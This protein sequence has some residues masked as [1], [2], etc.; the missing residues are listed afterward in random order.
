VRY[1]PKLADMVAAFEP[2]EHV[3]FFGRDATGPAHSASPE[4]GNHG[5]WPLRHDYRSTYILS[6]PGVRPENLGTVEM[7]SLEERLSVPL[8]LNCPKPQ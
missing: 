8:G 1:A 2:A 3:Q 5:F 7:T 4:R 6:G